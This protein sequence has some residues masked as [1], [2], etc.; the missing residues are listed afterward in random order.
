MKEILKNPDR[1]A[2][3]DLNHKLVKVVL[4]KNEKGYWNLEFDLAHKQDIKIGSCPECG[5]DIIAF[6]KGFGCKNKACKFVLWKED[7]WLHGV[8]KKTITESMAKSLLTKGS[9]AVKGLWSEQRQAKFDA[10][11]Y[12]KKNAK[13][14]WGFGFNSKN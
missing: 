10:T 2:T 6:E 4:T 8:Y 5:Q 7:K 3:L 14:Y 13:G 12:F 9:V 1:K 11:V